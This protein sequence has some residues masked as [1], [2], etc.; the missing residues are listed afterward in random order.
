VFKQIFGLSVLRSADADPDDA[1]W[2][3]RIH[4]AAVGKEPKV[5]PEDYVIEFSVSAAT[6]H[7][8]EVGHECRPEHAPL[9]DNYAHSELRIY[10]HSPAPVKLMKREKDLNQDGKVRVAVFRARLSEAASIALKP[11]E[12]NRYL[13]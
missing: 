2:D 6:S 7:S 1:R 11:F 12:G 8:P 10:R 4:C 13:T 5:Y 3:S 9:A